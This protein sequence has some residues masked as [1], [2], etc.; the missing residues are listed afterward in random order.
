MQGKSQEQF[1]FGF[2]QGRDKMNFF[3]AMAESEGREGRSATIGPTSAHAN[4]DSTHGAFGLW[5]TIPGQGLVLPARQHQSQ[6]NGE[7]SWVKVRWSK[8]EDHPGNA[9]S[10]SQTWLKGIL[11]APASQKRCPQSLFIF[12]HR[13]RS[14]FQCQ[15]CL[16]HGGTHPRERN[17]P[18]PTSS[19]PTW[20]PHPSQQKLLLF[21]GLHL[22]KPSVGL[23]LLTQPKVSALAAL[24]V[25]GELALGGKGDA[26]SRTINGT[27]ANGSQNLLGGLPK[28]PTPFARRGGRKG[29]PYRKPLITSC[30]HKGFQ[31]MHR[32]LDKPLDRTPLPRMCIRPQFSNPLSPRATK[33][34]PSSRGELS[35]VLCQISPTEPFRGIFD[36]R[37]WGCWELESQ[38]IKK[39][40][41]SVGEWWSLKDLETTKQILTLLAGSFPSHWE[42][43]KL[44]RQA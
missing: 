1:D 25:G 36:H 26:K 32:A 34:V 10:N 42:R 21:P 37:S 19:F 24:A 12:R 15:V 27:G 9:F 17:A 7:E 14:F 39:G 44:F 35:H 2:S 20:P 33:A 13:E 22:H 30:L 31:V 18:S 28:F 6:K 4:S 41:T 5:C 8:N 40:P 11:L 3:Q 16:V 23:S 43:L 29:P 38:H